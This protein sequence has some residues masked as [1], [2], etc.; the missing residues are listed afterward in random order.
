MDW[1]T[2]KRRVKIYLRTNPGIPFIVA[3][4][5]IILSAAILFVVSNPWTAY[6]MAV[7]AFYFLCIGIATQIGI[8]LW[9]AKKGP[10]GHGSSKITSS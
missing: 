5:V 1:P 4:Q 8:S 9:R 6:D 2:T 10:K 7:Y 3:F